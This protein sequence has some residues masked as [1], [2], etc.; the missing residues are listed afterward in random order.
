MF[1]L[2]ES[3]LA[4]EFSGLGHF[5]VWVYTFP[6]SEGAPFRVNFHCKAPVKRIP[7]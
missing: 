4:L 7:V 3:L 1:V 2:S 6:R 5:I